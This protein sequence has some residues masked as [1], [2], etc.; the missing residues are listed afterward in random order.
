MFHLATRD[1]ERAC[2]GSELI[3][4]VS[5]KHVSIEAEWKCP[6]ASTAIREGSA[7]PPVAGLHKED[8]RSPIS[9]TTMAAVL[10][11][12]ILRRPKTCLVD[13]TDRCQLVVE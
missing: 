1:L 5:G 11:P 3:S 12:L 9:K 7:T 6:W 4:G 13:F 8:T 10:W 2:C